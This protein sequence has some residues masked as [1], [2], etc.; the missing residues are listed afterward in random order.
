MIWRSIPGYKNIY[1]ASPEGLIRR[2]APARGLSVPM[3]MKQYIGT[4]GYCRIF[5]S[6]RHKKKTLMVHN[7]ILLAFKGLPK[8]GEYGSH[9]DGI[10]RNNNLENLVWRTFSAIQYNTYNNLNKK[11]PRGNKHHNAKL[12]EIDIKGIKSLL[13]S[14][15]FTNTEIAKLF[16]IS[17]SNISSISSNKTWAHVKG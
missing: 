8:E 3:L 1:E 14:K 7:L 4:D 9:L 12:T 15:H 10:R 5:I 6:I 17:K 11:A 13:I 2:I 16:K